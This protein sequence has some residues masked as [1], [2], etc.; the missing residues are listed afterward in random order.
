MDME[1]A[2]LIGRVEKWRSRRNSYMYGA[3]ALVSLVILVLISTVN[4]PTWMQNITP[5]AYLQF[6]GISF[7]I[8]YLGERSRK[9]ETA[10]LQAIKG[11]VESS[12]VAE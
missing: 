6:V 3:I 1:I 11:L 2:N 4:L 9:N 7:V 5:W 8:A 10:L 12:M